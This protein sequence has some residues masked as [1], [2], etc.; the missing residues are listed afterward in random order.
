[1]LFSPSNTIE[2]IKAK[3]AEEPEEQQPVSVKIEES[4]IRFADDT[5]KVL[6]KSIG[7]LEPG[8]NVHY[9]SYGNF[10]LV[11]LMMHLIKQTG[12]VHAFMTS[13]SFS[14]KSIEQLQKRLESGELLSFRVIVDNR[15]K[16]LSPK[17]FQMLTECFNYRCSSIH[18]KV[19]LLWNET[20]N[21]SVVTSQN[22]TDNSKMERGTIFTNR[23]VFEFDL[24]ALENEFKRGT[25]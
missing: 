18:A 21:L 2:E 11:R 23:K 3:R 7:T 9:Y 14:Q 4:E 16:S 19:A 8:K 17:P 1:M 6:I 20:W 12:P 5:D 10:N 22:A 24:T 25:T 13:Y 15:V